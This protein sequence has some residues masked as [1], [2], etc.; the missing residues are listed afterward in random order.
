MMET[1]FLVKQVKQDLLRKNCIATQNEP[2][3]TELS[4]SVVVNIFAGS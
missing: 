2:L 4:I 3:T 1:T